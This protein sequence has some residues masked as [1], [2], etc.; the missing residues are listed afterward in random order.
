MRVVHTDQVQVSAFPLQR[1]GLVHQDT[2]PEGLDRR[3]HAKA[4]VIAQHGEH[5]IGQLG[6]D[7]LQSRQSRFFRA[8]R[9]RAKITGDDAGIVFNLP[10]RLG[11]GMGHV[12][13][14][15]E[16]GI[17]KMQQTET[18]EGFGKSGETNLAP[19]EVDITRIPSSTPMHPGEAQQAAHQAVDGVP[20]FDVEEGA[21]L[22]EDLGL[23]LGLDAEPLAR[24]ET[25]DPCLEQG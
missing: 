9:P 22:T 12:H 13:M 3:Q 5:G 24:M 7:P 21:A 19:G 16:V 2:N 8:K 15:V 18:I 11:D 10:H 14:H 25:P 1:H 17:G 20:V 23:V 4:V 6:T